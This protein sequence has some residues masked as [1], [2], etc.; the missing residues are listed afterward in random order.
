[1]KR[2]KKGEEGV[3]VRAVLNPHPT[4]QQTHRDP[5]SSGTHLTPR[6]AHPT[7]PSALAGVKMPC[8]GKAAKKKKNHIFHSTP[9]GFNCKDAG[10]AGLGLCQSPGAWEGMQPWD[11]EDEGAASLDAGAFLPL[12]PP[13]G[14]GQRRGTVHLEKH[15]PF[16]CP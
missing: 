6:C 2:I 4:S 1:M 13:R 16:P 5:A 10:G 9:V 3:D 15:Y 7:H 12:Q 11:E 8:P 14:L